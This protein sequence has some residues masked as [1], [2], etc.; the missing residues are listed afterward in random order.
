MFV[1]FQ[2]L[3][4]NGDRRDGNLGNKQMQGESISNPLAYEND[5]CNWRWE[6]GGSRKE[7]WLKA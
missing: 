6:L 1:C 2:A 7:L 4:I 3:A 5:D